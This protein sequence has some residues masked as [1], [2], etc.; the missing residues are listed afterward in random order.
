MIILSL[1]TSLFPVILPPLCFSYI[2]LLEVVYSDFLF[3][4]IATVDYN[5][6]LF[7]QS[8]DFDSIFIFVDFHIHFC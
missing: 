4:K 6:T 5:I 1:E 2:I 7:W 8:N 3:S